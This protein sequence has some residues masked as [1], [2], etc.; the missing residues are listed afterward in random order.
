MRTLLLACFTSF[1]AL[2]APEFVPIQERA[3]GQSLAGSNLMN[4]SLTL[5]RLLAPF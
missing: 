1:L 2:G 4:D 5:T 3:Q